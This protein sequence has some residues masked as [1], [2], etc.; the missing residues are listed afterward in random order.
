MI[1]IPIK[2]SIQIMQTY[3]TKSM[4]EIGCGKGGILSQFPFQT[5]IGIDHF[6]PYILEAKKH[7]PNDIFILGDIRNLYTYFTSCSFDTIIGFDILE[8]L[9]MLDIEK[10]ILMSE[11][12]SKKLVIFFFPSGENSAYF[13]TE[14]VDI[15]PSMKHITVLEKSFFENKGYSTHIYPDYHGKGFD[16]CLAIKEL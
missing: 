8:H 13:I 9:T 12:I 16:G 10:V 15:N 1:S 2:Q 11:E 5:K 4:L 3:G 7:N 6:E 14:D